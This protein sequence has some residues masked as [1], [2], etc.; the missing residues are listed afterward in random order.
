MVK[1]NWIKI[2]S[3]VSFV[4]FLAACNQVVTPSLPDE[5]LAPPASTAPVVDTQTA[6]EM[7]QPTPPPGM[8]FLIEKAREDLA[9]RLSIGLTQIS[10]VEARAVVWPDSSLG[11][12]QPGM[13]YLQVPEDGALIIL[14]AQGIVYEYHNGGSR[15]LFLCEMVYKDPYTPP[16]IDL[17]DLTPSSRD[18]NN[19]P[20]LTP[21]NSIPPGE[22]Q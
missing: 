18:K 19:P 2:T 1:H 3:I 6:S 10:L 20:P 16:K 13:R 21:D 15:G 14:Q 9:Q 8:E 22:D 11:C 5:A 7:T 4:I 17:H 12:P